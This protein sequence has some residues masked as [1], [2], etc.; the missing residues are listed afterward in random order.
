MVFLNPA[1][2][3]GLLAASVPVLIHLLNLRKLEKIEFS[4]LAFLKELQKTKIRRIKLKQWI[5]LALRV[6]IIL[7]LVMAF[8]RPALESVSPGGVSSAAK[9]SA[10]FIIDNS[11][12]MSVI[13]ENGSLINQAKQIAKNLL[14]E[15]QEGDE[16]SIIPLTIVGESENKPT[17]NII[18]AERLVD[19]IKLSQVYTPFEKKLQLA[20][21][22]LR[23]SSNYNKEVFVISDLQS[24]LIIDDNET[25]DD[26]LLIF[27]ENTKIYSMKLNRSAIRNIAVTKLQVNNQIFEKGKPVSFNA[28]IS[29]YSNVSIENVVSSLFINGQRAA[30]KSISLQPNQS[31]QVGF[32]TTL[33]GSG[34]LEI[35]VE[36]EDDDILQDNRRFMSLLIPEKIKVLLLA[37]NLADLDYIG[38]IFTNV[39][40]NSFEVDQNLL[41]RISAIN[42]QTYN[43]VLISGSESLNNNKSLVDYLSLGGK[44]ML[45]P[46]NNSTLNGFK[47]LCTLLDI[48]MPTMLVDNP[49]NSELYS[50]IDKTDFDHPV[51]SNI[52]ERNSKKQFQSPTVNKYF[53]ISAE[54]KGTRIISL[55]DGTSF[56]SEFSVKNGSVILFNVA[57]VLTWSDFPIKGIFA[58]LVTNSVLYLTSKTNENVDYITGDI[59]SIRTANKTINQLKIVHPD[60]S[61]EFLDYDPVRNLNFMPYTKSF[62]PGVYK[63]FSA[64]EIIDVLCVNVNPIESETEYIEYRDFENYLF[65]KGFKGEVIEIMQGDNFAEKISQARFGM[66]LWKHFLIA[67]LF[68]SLIEMFIARNTKKDL[69]KINE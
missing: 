61:G 45:F 25:G 5:L 67:A 66:E 46:G 12:S 35:F 3:L 4:T 47:S 55:L 53:N 7:F 13:D 42:L 29:N 56:M 54:A 1:I 58:P 8:A 50:S 69:A 26:S 22:V 11:F 39:L 37:D 63:V 6:L 31:T 19:E 49:E 32:E 48:P 18:L 9:T 2:L 28:V 27:P 36:L 20:N 59:L 14:N 15:F 34:L 52:F 51:F 23:E 17:T 62:L 44:I 65:K 10:V 21:N 38:A 24:N 57:P 40:G 43:V 64:N 41:T 60:L 30:Q 33:T 68:L 16:I